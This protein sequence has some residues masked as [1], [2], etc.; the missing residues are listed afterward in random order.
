M[1]SLRFKL[2]AIFLAGVVVAALVSAVIALRLIQNVTEAQARATLLRQAQGLAQLY[3]KGAIEAANSNLRAPKFAAATLEAA[4]GT[5]IYYVGVPLFPGQISGLRH[6]NRSYVNFTA[7]KQGR[8]QSLMFTPPGQK[9]VYVAAVVPL[10]LGGQVFGG[11][12]VAKLRSDLRQQLLI[13]LERIALGLLAG[14]AA[15][16]GLFSWVSRRLTKPLASLATAADGVAAGDYSVSIPR[17]DSNDEIGHLSN[18]F[19]DMVSLL[20]ETNEL[21]RQFLMKVSH[22]LRT[23][24][25]SITGHA[26]ALLEGLADDDKEMHDSSLAVIRDESARLG[27]LVGDLLDLAKLQARRFVLHEEEV[28]ISSLLN[29]AY[30]SFSTEALRREIE[31][32]RSLSANPMIVTDGDRLLQVV[33][34]LLGNAFQWTPDGGLIGLSLEQDADEIVISVEDTGPGIPSEEHDKVIVPF[35]SQNRRGTGLGLAIAHELSEALGG[36][37]SFYS[38]PGRGSRFTLTLPTSTPD[39]DDEA[40]L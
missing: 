14:L 4:T 7:I 20:S 27:R 17:L 6:L 5:R 24:L 32:E 29:R 39:G 35:W 8:T 10:K 18:R 25:T 1:H 22:E 34:N 36:H 2:P 26:E 31:F 3:S 30:R 16:A 38:E 21:A 33:T 15:A 13:L 28:P 11:L 19:A 40:Q 9:N 12:V 37:L 23:P